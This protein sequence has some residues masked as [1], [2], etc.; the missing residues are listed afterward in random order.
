MYSGTPAALRPTYTYNCYYCSKVT[1]I[2]KHYYRD[3]LAYA[4]YI[5]HVS[6]EMQFTPGF[7]YHSYY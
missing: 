5:S 6:P 3:V 4:P 2:F 7:D 1:L